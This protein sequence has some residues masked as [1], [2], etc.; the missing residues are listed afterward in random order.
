MKQIAK[1]QA[2]AGQTHAPVFIQLIFS[3]GLL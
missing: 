2:L 3:P 1:K